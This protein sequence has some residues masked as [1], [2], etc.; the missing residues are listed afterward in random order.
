[1]EWEEEA[2]KVKTMFNEMQ[3]EEVAKT[4][5]VLETVEKGHYWEGYWGTERHIKWL[6]LF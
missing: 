3:K 4:D 2:V 6:L 1:M 5:Q